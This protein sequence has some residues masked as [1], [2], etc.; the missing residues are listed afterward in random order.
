MHLAVVY[1]LLFEIVRYLQFSTMEEKT[2][3]KCQVL[4]E[5]NEV[6]AVKALSE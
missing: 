5:V 3:C 6:T 4:Y 2:F 1:S